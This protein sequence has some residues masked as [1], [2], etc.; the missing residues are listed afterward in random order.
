M[1]RSVLNKHETGGSER[2]WPAQQGAQSTR[3]P[4]KSSEGRAGSRAGGWC[5][6][7]AQ[8]GELQGRERLHRA[9]TLQVPA[10]SVCH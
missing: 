3:E 4:S 8:P 10:L 1:C 2:A 7:Q 5:W 6:T 9:Q